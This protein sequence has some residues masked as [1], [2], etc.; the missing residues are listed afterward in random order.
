MP[1]KDREKQTE[2]Q[3]LYN[4]KRVE[5]R[6]ERKPIIAFEDQRV[7]VRAYVK[8]KHYNEFQAIVTKLAVKYR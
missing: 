6:R 1:Y 4:V 5:E 3:Q 8:R 2:W 7:C